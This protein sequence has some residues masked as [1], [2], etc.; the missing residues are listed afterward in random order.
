MT[1]ISKDTLWKGIIEDLFEDF[2]AYFFPEWAAEVADFSKPMEF[3]DKELE[4]IAPEAS[5]QKRYADKLIKVFTKT[6]DEQWILIHIEVQGYQDEHFAQRMFTYFYR[7]LDRHQQKIMALAILTDNNPDFHPQ[8]YT[9]K[10]E[11]TTHTYTFPSFKILQ[12]TEEMLDVAGNPFSLIMLTAKKALN[13]ANLTDKA[14]FIW[15]RSLIEALKE[16]NYSR[17]KI[18]TILDFIRFYVRFDKEENHQTLNKNIQTIFKQRQ[19]MGIQEAILQ[20]VREQG[21]S[22]GIEQGLS[23]GIEQGISQGIELTTI[24]VVL[25]MHKKGFSLEDIMKATDLS[26][27]QIELI[28]A[29]N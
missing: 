7:I 20:E 4:A 27:A 17:E 29:N 14:Q 18:H 11:N 8:K 12:K 1:N 13:Q 9:Y 25:R 5:S 2:C 3:L 21:L 19:N 16:A 10:Y 15:K 26:Q 6:G 24:K 22:Q 28:L 23:Q